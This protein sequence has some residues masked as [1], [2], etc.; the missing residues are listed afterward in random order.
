MYAQHSCKNFNHHNRRHF[1]RTARKSMLQF[2]PLPHFVS[3]SFLATICNCNCLLLLLSCGNWQLLAAFTIICICIIKSHLLTAEH[4]TGK[5]PAA[6]S[7]SST[8]TTPRHKLQTFISIAFA[9]KSTNISNSNESCW[10]CAC[11][12]ACVCLC[13]C[14]SVSK[15][16]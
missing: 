2:V 6:A 4:E 11:V 13:L 15:M 3:H 1:I 8:C 7:S 9:M 14:E 12:C 10:L 16:C 5:T